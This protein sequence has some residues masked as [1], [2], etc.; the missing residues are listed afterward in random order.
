MEILGGANDSAIRS[1]V[2][3]RASV[4]AKQRPGFMTPVAAHVYIRFGANIMVPL[5]MI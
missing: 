3:G 2:G 1:N 4:V 5:R